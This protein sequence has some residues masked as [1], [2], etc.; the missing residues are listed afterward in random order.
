MKIFYIANA[1]IPTEKAHGLTIVKSC[2]AFARAGARVTLLV[3]RRKTQFEKDLFDTYSIS[4]TFSVRHLPTLDLL[5][6][7]SSRFAFFIAYA[8]FFISVFFVLLRAKKDDTVIYTRDTPFLLL[9]S[10]GIPAVLE[11]H[12][13]FAKQRVYF[14]LAR[15]AKGIITISQALKQKFIGAR[16]GEGNIQVEPSGV[17]LSTFALDMPRDA[18][19]QSLGLP[20]ELPIILYSGNFTTM[21]QD[22]GISDI[23][24]SLSHIQGVLF[25][26]AGGSEK[27]LARYEKEAKKLNV[28]SRVALKGFA[29][30]AMLSVYQQAADIALMPFPDTPHYRSN[31]SPVKMFEY[32]ASSRPIIASDLPT[33]REV[34]NE[35]NAVLVPPGNPRALAQAIGELLKNPE[36]AQTLARR[37]REEVEHYTW[38]ARSQRVLSFIEERRN[39]AS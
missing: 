20:R 30:Q 5:R 3:P 10:L 7:S 22:K 15:R 8:T 16:F 12:H 39:R 6:F 31:M 28:E 2:E 1:R 4:R 17:E 11:C 18:A 37:A 35:K 29:P 21:G 25:V 33:I 38:G 23:L 27:D 13:V 14:W 19:R 32:M 26:A 34:L 9:T 36:R 24:H